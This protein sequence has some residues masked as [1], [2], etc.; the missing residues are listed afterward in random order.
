MKI[1]IIFMSAVLILFVLPDTPAPTNADDHGF[2]F[3]RIKY[4]TNTSGGRWGRRG[5]GSGAWS[6]DYPTAEYNLYE[7]L[8]RSTKIKVHGEPLI[9]TLTDNRI[10]EYP[11]LYLCEPG[12]WHLN[13][14]EAENLREYFKR[15]GFVLFDD[16][17]GRREWDNFYYQIKLV[18]PDKEPEEIPNDHPVWS[19]Y[20]EIDPVEAPSLVSG[21]YGRYDDQYYTMFDKKGRMMMIVCYNQ[22]IGDGWEWPGSNFNQGASEAFKMGIN[23]I[24][25]ALTH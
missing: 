18:F 19:V 4:N 9:L 20:Y 5:G 25:W 7:A 23:F 17:R 21:G 12:Y 22:D 15:G 13:E 1:F 14:K 24:I 3:V 16:F 2:R 11:F 6:H 8:D 10:F